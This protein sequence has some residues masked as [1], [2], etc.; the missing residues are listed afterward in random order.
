MQY[1]NWMEFSQVVPAAHAML[2]MFV[3]QKIMKTTIFSTI[4]NNFNNSEL[5]KLLKL[6]K[7]LEFSVYFS[8]RA[9]APPYEPPGQPGS[10]PFKLKNACLR[11]LIQGV[12]WEV[13]IDP[14][15]AIREI[16]ESCWNCWKLLKLLKIVE[17]VENDNFDSLINSARSVCHSMRL[18]TRRARVV[19]KTVLQ[20]RLVTRC[21]HAA[22]PVPNTLCFQQFQQF[23]QFSTIMEL[24]KLLKLLKSMKI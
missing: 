10:S 3:L 13:V 16:V 12:S 11:F 23:Q 19:I 2:P 24:L 14:S 6:L 1:F 18:H 9:S 22:P 7:I 4:F 15:E 17:I 5:L 21:L 20:G 8:Y